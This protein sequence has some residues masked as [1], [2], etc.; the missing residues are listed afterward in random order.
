MSSWV[1]GTP[2][3]WAIS[4]S[5]LC[6]RPRLVGWIGRAVRARFRSQ[7]IVC[8]NPRPRRFARADQLPISIQ[9]GARARP[10]LRG[11]P[12]AS[13]RTPIIAPT[14]SLSSFSSTNDV[15]A[16][17]GTR[18]QLSTVAQPHPIDRRID[19]DGAFPSS[20]DLIR[21]MRREFSIYSRAASEA[22]ASII[23]ILP[24]LAHHACTV[25]LVHE[26]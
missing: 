21:P 10:G 18:R 19:A 11:H 4:F 25:I 17:T 5:A 23:A 14:G 16:G 15:P 3:S 12:S 1:E 6:G 2:A 7:F 26:N 20:T 9:M 24:S 8:N 13:S 22:H